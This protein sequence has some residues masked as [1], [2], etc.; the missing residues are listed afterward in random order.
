MSHPLFVCADMNNEIKTLKF[1]I[2]SYNIQKVCA[3]MWVS[4]SKNK[5]GKTR[6]KNK[7]KTKKIY[8]DCNMSSIA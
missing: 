4:F 3:C 5:R 7:R 2:H 6:E 1:S 8:I